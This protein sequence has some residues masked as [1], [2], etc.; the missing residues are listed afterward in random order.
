MLSMKELTQTYARRK[1]Y[2]LR[3]H[4][5]LKRELDTL[6]FG[7]NKYRKIS[8]DFVSYPISKIIEEDPILCYSDISS[9]WVKRVFD[10]HNMLIISNLEK[11]YFIG[12]YNN[13]F[14]FEFKKPEYHLLFSFNETGKYKIIKDDKTTIELDDTFPKNIWDL[15]DDHLMLIRLMV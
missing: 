1:F 13:F 3:L 4:S 14:E 8:N 11:S 15:T 6:D 7:A 2:Y 9:A 10:M 12:K 5:L